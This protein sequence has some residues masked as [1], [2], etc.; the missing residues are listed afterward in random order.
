[1]RPLL[2]SCGSGP[3]GARTQK[4]FSLRS[5]GRLIINDQRSKRPHFAEEQKKDKPCRTITRPVAARPSINHRFQ[6]APDYGTCYNSGTSGI[7]SLQYSKIEMKHK[8]TTTKLAALAA[9]ALL[10]CSTMFTAKTYAC[11]AYNDPNS[12]PSGEPATPWDGDFVKRETLPGTSCQVDVMYCTRT[13][14]DGTV[15]IYIEQVAAVTEPACDGINPLLMVSGGINALLS[16]G[17]F[18][19]SLETNAIPGCPATTTFTVTTQSD[20]WEYVGVGAELPDNSY[21]E[22]AYKV[23]SYAGQTCNKT[24]TACCSNGAISYGTPTYTTV[25]SDSCPTPPPGT[26]ALF[27]CYS[28]ALCHTF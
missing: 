12:L 7:V 11:P 9:M 20:C 28:L 10:C 1:V 5:E 25:G 19:C 22:Y 15:Q 2:F 26:W 17:S 18:I 6:L 27:T 24:M 8:K 3:P 21:G 16:D 14:P 23:C 4:S 13:F